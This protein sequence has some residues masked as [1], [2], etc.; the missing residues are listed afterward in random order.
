MSKAYED[1]LRRMNAYRDERNLTQTEVSNL[2]GKTQS[3]FSKMELGK[4]VVP[5]EVL[6]KLQNVGGWDID[7]ILIGKKR[8]R[9]E[10]S[11]FDYLHANFDNDWQS[12]KEV[13]VWALG[14]H[15]ME[16]GSASGKDIDCEYK[17]LKMRMHQENSQTIL[18]E[19]RSI[20]GVTQ[21][22]MA[23]KLGVNIKKYTSLEKGNAC[24]DAE[25]LALI[26]N[27]SHCRPSLFFCTDYREM[28]RHL[29]NDLWNEINPEKQREI[30]SFLEH[31][32]KLHKL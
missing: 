1:F 26:Y 24:P 18:A 16:E 4:T 25:L 6:E 27:I 11:L 28:E 7:Y 17:L 31:A 14:Q 15:V 21:M 12:L 20:T 9:W 23:E 5:Y 3:Q 13:L 19:I 22:V 30:I 2:I 10:S 32:M 8:F 29:M